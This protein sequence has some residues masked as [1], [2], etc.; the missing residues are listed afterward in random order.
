MTAT[1]RKLQPFIER[2]RL[3]FNVYWTDGDGYM[4]GAIGED[5]T[6]DLPPYL[7]ARLEAYVLRRVKREFVSPSEFGPVS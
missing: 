4:E 6:V 5:Y 1:G 7:T 2:L 3:S